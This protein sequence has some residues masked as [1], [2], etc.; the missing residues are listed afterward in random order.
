MPGADCLFECG[1]LRFAPGHRADQ[2]PSPARAAWGRSR[3]QVR[4]TELHTCGL[5]RQQP[6]S[7][8]FYYDK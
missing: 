2:R 7:F 3:F 4:P 1:S 5:V 6:G 8:L